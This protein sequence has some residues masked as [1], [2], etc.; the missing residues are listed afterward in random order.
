MTGHGESG[1]FSSRA[2]G[3]CPKVKEHEK[4]VL[5]VLVL[6]LRCFLGSQGVCFAL[7]SPAGV[8]PFL[9]SNPA[10]SAHFPLVDSTQFL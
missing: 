7:V 6:W 1:A 10:W 8:H 5:R 9:E 3:S 2:W 4:Q